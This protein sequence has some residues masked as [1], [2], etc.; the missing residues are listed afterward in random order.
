MAVLCEL[1]SKG[2][3]TVAHPQQNLM[4]EA[5]PAEYRESL[6][7]RMEPVSF[8]IDTV[9]YKPGEVPQYAHFMTSGVTSIVTFMADGS[10]TEVG[11]I[12]REGLVEAFHLLGPAR[13]QTTGFVQLAGTALRMPFAD[14]QREFLGSEVVRSLILQAVQA[15]GLILNQLAA[16]NRLHEVEERLARWLLMVQDRVESEKFFLTQE[17]LAEML[18]ARRTTVTLAAGS[19]QRSGLIEYR[20][21]NIH[22]VDHEGLEGAA[23]ECYPIVRDLV[24]NLYK[25][26]SPRPEAL[27]AD[28]PI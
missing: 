27:F 8:A 28:Q 24:A 22:I 12:G 14:L 5:L 19:L 2:G 4:L 20:R 6:I 25:E 11:L 17:F 18:S 16:C 10:G 9:L 23:C 13:I 15:Q 7:S 26:Q 3:A 21:G 1:N